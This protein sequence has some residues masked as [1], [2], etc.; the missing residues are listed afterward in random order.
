MVTW[1]GEWMI[2]LNQASF[3]QQNV[4]SVKDVQQIYS[5]NPP[6]THIQF[7]LHS[8]VLAGIT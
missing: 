6:L 7:S 3:R 1:E 2:G 8:V 4:P 5:K